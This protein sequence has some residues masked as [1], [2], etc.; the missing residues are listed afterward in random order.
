MNLYIKCIFVVLAFMAIM[1]S[2]AMY[3]I[4]Q[5][6]KTIDQIVD[7]LHQLVDSDKFQIDN[8][9]SVVTILEKMKK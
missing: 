7:K 8:M 6:N 5:Q 1:L 3:N 4:H 2:V 9:D